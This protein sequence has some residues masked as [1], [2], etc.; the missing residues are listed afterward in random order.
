MKIL[1][2]MSSLQRDNFQSTNVVINR[3]IFESF[4]NLNL[5]SIQGLVQMVSFLLMRKVGFDQNTNC[6]FIGG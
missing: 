2:L 4:E 1:E 5:E 6:V 3:L